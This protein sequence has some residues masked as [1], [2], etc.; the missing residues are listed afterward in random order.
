M[1]HIDRAIIIYTPFCRSSSKK[2]LSAVRVCTGA[3]SV[4]NHHTQTVTQH[5][6]MYLRIPANDK[7]CVP[8]ISCR[9]RMMEGV[10]QRNRIGGKFYTRSALRVTGTCIIRNPRVCR[11]VAHATLIASLLCLLFVP[12]SALSDEAG[13]ASRATA[14]IFAGV[15]LNASRLLGLIEPPAIRHGSLKW[16]GY[17][18]F[19][20]VGVQVLIAGATVCLGWYEVDSST[21]DWLSLTPASGIL[22][23][24]ALCAKPPKNSV[25][26]DGVRLSALFSKASLTNVAVNFVVVGTSLLIAAF[27]LTAGD[28]ITGSLNIAAILT[29][30]FGGHYIKDVPSTY[31]GG[32]VHEAIY[33]SPTI[34]ERTNAYFFNLRTRRLEATVM[35]GAEW[36]NR[37]LWRSKYAEIRRLARPGRDNFLAFVS[38]CTPVIQNMAEA[39]AQNK[40]YINDETSWQTIFIGLSEAED[41]ALNT[42]TLPLQNL[43]YMLAVI[44]R[45]SYRT[46]PRLSQPPARHSDSSYL[47]WNHLRHLST[48]YNR[49]NNIWTMTELFSPP[50]QPRIF[51]RIPPYNIE[52]EWL[53]PQLQQSDLSKDDYDAG[54]DH[55]VRLSSS[56]PVVMLVVIEYFWSLNYGNQGGRYTPPE[57]MQRELLESHRVTRS[58]VSASVD[59]QMVVSILDAGTEVFKRF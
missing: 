57:G 56:W 58:L 28:V 34:G 40:L 6:D 20:V 38:E 55:A 23:I 11:N 45:V 21:A 35:R 29:A 26:L 18:D 24:A 22:G 32:P 13:R 54:I 59:L 53:R 47:I 2:R 8:Q 51:E 17:L 33:G 12:A 19:A 39:E 14:I 15:M 50:E 48:H 7:I 31:H 37:T 36:E 10:P 27:Q 25:T 44:E 5:T 1:G 16:R 49:E 42:S 41:K 9:R 46:G 30:L 52:T 43:W 4:N 3:V